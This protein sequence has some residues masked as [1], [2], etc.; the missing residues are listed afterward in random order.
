MS[1]SCSHRSFKNPLLVCSKVLR[2]K[3]LYEQQLME[4]QELY[5][6]QQQLTDILKDNLERVQVFNHQNHNLTFSYFVGSVSI[7]TADIAIKSCH[8]H[9]FNYRD[10]LRKVN[11]LYLISKKVA[12]KP[13][14]Q[15]KRRITWYIMSLVLVRILTYS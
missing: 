15:L 12:D 9:V 13:R 4:L 11:K 2:T 14:I 10:N 8:V 5:I 6:Y 3:L 7:I 1:S